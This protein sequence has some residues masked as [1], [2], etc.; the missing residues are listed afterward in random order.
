MNVNWVIA[1]VLLVGV[2]W[3]VHATRQLRDPLLWKGETVYPEPGPTIRDAFPKNGRPRFDAQI[4][5]NQKGYRATWEIKGDTLW[6]ISLEGK[7]EG[8]KVGIREL[9]DGRSAPLAATWF[10]GT[11]I[12]PRGEE[13]GLMKKGEL[14]YVW[15]KETH[16]TV[17]KGKVTK[18]E[19]MVFDPDKTPVWG[20]RN[21][22][23]NRSTE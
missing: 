12:V 1:I 13:I 6:L 15:T 4:S 19:E 17:E 11:V 23:T 21:R 2:P 14:R 22:L 3:P 5:I 9:F 18:V 10:S 7:I 16:I 8:K 20:R